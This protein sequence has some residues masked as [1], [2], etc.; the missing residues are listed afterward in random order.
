MDV[1]V[2]F[3]TTD[4]KSR[5]SE[6]LTP[7]ERLAFARAMLADVVDA[8]RAGGGDPC[9]LATAPI[10]PESSEGGTDTD[11]DGVSDA[12]DVRVVVDESPLTTA[13]ND[14]LRNGV[15][16]AGVT[17]VDS[18]PTAVVMADLALAT[19]ETVGRL[20]GTDGDVVIAP[21]RGGGTNALVV[22]HPGFYVDYHGAS[23][24]DH[25]RIAADVDA[26][27]QVFDSHR[28]ASDVDAPI[29]L[30]EVIVHADGRAAD[31]LRD[32][33]FELD[34]SDGRVD[35]VRADG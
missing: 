22:R 8:V 7:G 17:A 29:D 18:S 5:L 19:P 9:V 24:L 11:L 2:P 35:V 3:S 6:R 4:P 10:E 15:A 31:W 30:V 27:V 25:R 26:S 28:L 12:D 34:R 13:V 23:Y 16:R 33:G 21:G 32:A 14:V 1:L 20:L